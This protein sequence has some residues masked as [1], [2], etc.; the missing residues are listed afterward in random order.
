MALPGAEHGACIGRV[1]AVLDKIDTKSLKFPNGVSGMTVGEMIAHLEQ[2]DPLA[3]VLMP[4]ENGGLDEIVVV[5]ARGVRLNVNRA[6]G[7]G[8]HEV[9]AFGEMADTDAVL[10]L[11]AN[12]LADDG[13]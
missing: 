4:A 6:E 12:G 8:P 11:S 7:F 9:P 10:L 1:S 2:L 13:S 3:P 5:T